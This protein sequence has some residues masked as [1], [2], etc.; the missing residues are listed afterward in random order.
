[1]HLGEEIT[2]IPAFIINMAGCNLACP[3]CPERCRFNNRRLPID[4]PQHYATQLAQYFTTRSM[5]K[6]VE[7]IGGEPSV[8]L[9]FVLDTS[10]RLREIMQAQCP[11]ILLNTNGYFDVSLLN[12][13]QGTIDGFVFDLKCLPTCQKE[14]TGASDYW[15]T[16]IPVMH[17]AYQSFKGPYIVRHLV[18]PGHTRCCTKPIIEWCHKNLPK[19]CF[20]LMTGFEDFRPNVTTPREISAQERENARQWLLDAHFENYLIDGN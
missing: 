6:T 15:E 19:A 3:T 8:Q 2:I 1:M 17:S 20:N 16:L 9:P 13:M 10:Q 12:A 4:D 7:W 14:I 5:P 18:M 11:L